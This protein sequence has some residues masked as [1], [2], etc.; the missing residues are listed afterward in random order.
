MQKKDHR[1]AKAA[2][3]ENYPLHKDGTY[4]INNDTLSNCTF[5]KVSYQVH[6]TTRLELKEYIRM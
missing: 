5:P 1:C 4:L 3:M 2:N 6:I